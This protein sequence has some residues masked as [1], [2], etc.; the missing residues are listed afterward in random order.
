M[1]KSLRD[2][3]WAPAPLFGNDCSCS[4][5]AH[6]LRCRSA[7]LRL[8]EQREW[9]S[10]AARFGPPVI[11]SSPN[12]SGK[13]P[14]SAAV[15]RAHILAQPKDA[16]K[17]CFC[18]FSAHLSAAQHKRGDSHNRCCGIMVRMWRTAAQMNP[19]H[20]GRLCYN[21]RWIYWCLNSSAVDFI[22]RS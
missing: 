7:I 20:K 5:A 22:M 14:N 21:P 17:Y 18:T 12:S 1:G 2:H 19:Q 16:Q 4:R 6:F 8:A 10:A 11:I 15:C 13:T 9:R 3:S